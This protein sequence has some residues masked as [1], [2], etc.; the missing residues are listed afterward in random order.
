[1][2]RTKHEKMS[3]QFITLITFFLCC[4]LTAYFILAPAYSAQSPQRPYF[5]IDGYQTP[6]TVFRIVYREPSAIFQRQSGTIIS[7]ALWRGRFYFCSLN[8]NRI[9]QITGKQERMVYKHNT[10]IRDIALDSGGNLYFSEAYGGERDGRIYRLTP[11]VNNLG[12][13]QQ[14]YISKKDQPINILLKTVDGFYGGDFTF[15]LQ[16]NLYLTSGNRPPAFIYKIDKTKGGKYG[17]P[18]KIYKETK[19]A[20]KGVAIDPGNPNSAYYADWKQ[21]IY[22]LDIK[23]QRRSVEF[24]QKVTESKTPRLSDVAFDM[25][26]RGKK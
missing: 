20:I 22:R 21:T 19:G 15:D 2:L 18:K 10:Y 26:I 5:I 9:F 24:T 17:A 13:K 7:I 12:S 8:D 4:G 16:D 6:G 14:F 25:S 1:M 3:V 11:T 23:S